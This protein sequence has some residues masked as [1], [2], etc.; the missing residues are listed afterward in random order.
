MKVICV[1]SQRQHCR[2]A[3]VCV[4]PIGVSVEFAFYEPTEGGK[5][6]RE[7]YPFNEY[8]ELRGIVVKKQ[9][10]EAWNLSLLDQLVNGVGKRIVRCRITYSAFVDFAPY[11]RGNPRLRYWYEHRLGVVG[12]VVGGRWAGVR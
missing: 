2:W 10:G 8:P 12:C 7:H 5:L 1:E 3:R 4:T 9:I 6:E 11:L